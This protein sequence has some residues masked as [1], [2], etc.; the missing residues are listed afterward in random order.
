LSLDYKLSAINLLY[1]LDQESIALRQLLSCHS[2]GY[3]VISS[4]SSDV[5]AW[6][7]YLIVCCG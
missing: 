6:C 1:G 5:H 7:D 4:L 3:E 2:S